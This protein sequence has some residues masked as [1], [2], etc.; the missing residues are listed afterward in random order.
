MGEKDRFS[1]WEGKRAL[2]VAFH[3]GRMES[4]EMLTSPPILAVKRIVLCQFVR[5]FIGLLCL[6]LRYIL[7]S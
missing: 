1:D 3:N 2:S 6:D 4:T 7:Y 5:D